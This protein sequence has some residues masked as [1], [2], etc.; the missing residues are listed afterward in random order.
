MEI[1]QAFKKYLHRMQVSRHFRP[2]ELHDAMEPAFCENGFRDS[3]GTVENI[4]I[5][6]LDVMGD[7]ILTSGLF[8]E[9][10]RNYPKAHITAVVGHALLSF[11]H[12]C[13]YCDEIFDFNRRGFEGDPLAYLETMEAFCEKHLRER[14]YDLCLLPQWGDDKRTTM[15]LA[16]MSGARKRIGYSDGALYQYFNALGKNPGYDE[17][18]ENAFLSQ[19]VF[20]PLEIIHEA[21]R[22]FYLLE[23]AGIPVKDNSLELWVNEKSVAKASDI[24]MKGLPQECIPVVLGIGAGGD[25][26]KYPAIKYGDAVNKIIEKY[27]SSLRFII[28]G[29]KTEEADASYLQENLPQDSVLNLVGKT[30]LD[31]SMAIISMASLYLGNDS[32]LMHAAAAVGVPVIVLYREAVDKETLIPGVFSEYA[33]FAPW[34]VK[35]VALRPAHALGGC[36][37][38]FVYGGCDKLYSHCITQIPP[39]EIVSAFDQIAGGEKG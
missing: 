6:R 14:K 10:R 4:L 29:G 28:L 30:S 33:R 5:I 22:N 31:E 19:A 38:A 24:L 2:Q 25:G 35:H 32:G 37:R 15:M 36:A 16:Y 20:N 17:S 7:M 11:M 39:D 34:H 23:A 9:V 21:A 12:V 27:G 13:P 8:R 26:R 3:S 18:Y 1:G